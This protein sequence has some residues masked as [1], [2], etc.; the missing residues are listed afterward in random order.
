MKCLKQNLKTQNSFNFVNEV[1]SVKFYVNTLK[2]EKMFSIVNLLGKLSQ[3]WRQVRERC[4][5]TE[6]FL[7]RI[8]TFYTQC[9]QEKL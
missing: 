5:N 4:P 3:V 1:N 8:W 6:F 2:V 9:N 7:I